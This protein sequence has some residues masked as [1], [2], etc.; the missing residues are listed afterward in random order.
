VVDSSSKIY[1]R[2]KKNM[3]AKK[4]IINTAEKVVGRAKAGGIR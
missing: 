1:S 4:K 2:L 3:I